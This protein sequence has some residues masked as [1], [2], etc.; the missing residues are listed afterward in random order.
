MQVPPDRPRR[1]WRDYRTT[2][3]RRPVKEFIVGLPIDDQAA[4]AAAMK[5]VPVFGN[6]SAH[7]LRGDTV[8]GISY[9]R[10]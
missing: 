2:S 7:H 5:D 8:I 1:R 4:I 9:A 6:A 3:G 10:C